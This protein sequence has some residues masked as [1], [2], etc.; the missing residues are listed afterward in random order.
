VIIEIT[1]TNANTGNTIITD[2]RAL[3]T[4]QMITKRLEQNNKQITCQGYI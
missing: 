2:D 3:E 4:Y 1:T